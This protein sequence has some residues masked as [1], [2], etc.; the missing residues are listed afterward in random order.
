MQNAIHCYQ[1]YE[2]S[3]EQE[4]DELSLRTREIH[5]AIWRFF[6]NPKIEDA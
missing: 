3:L 2:K 5:G 1:H 6:R 4:A